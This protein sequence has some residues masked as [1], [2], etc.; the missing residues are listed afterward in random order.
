MRFSATL[1]GLTRYPPGPDYS[2]VEQLTPSDFQRIARAADDLGYHA[3][4]VSEHIVMP[5]ELAPMMGAHWPH[6]LTAMAFLAGCTTRI[7]V[8][9]QVIV[10]PYHNPLSLAKAVA[11]LD[12]L[13]GG[14]VMLAVGIGH[15]ESEF[16]ALGVPFQERGRMADEYLKAMKV[17]WTED[18]PAYHGQFV[19]FD[20]VLF[21]PKPVQRPSPGSGSAGIPRRRSAGPRAT[22]KAGCPGW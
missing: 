9:A 12:V 2:W 21:E 18:A 17:L 4:V 7:A 14:R 8:N 6:G 3:L 16:R 15:A 11:T 13:S 19:N 1:P 5:R 20:D 22:V 10:L